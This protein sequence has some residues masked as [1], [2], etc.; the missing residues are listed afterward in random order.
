MEWGCILKSYF[1]LIS[2]KS[3]FRPIILSQISLRGPNHPHP[4][5]R[6]LI[7]CV[8]VWICLPL[9]DCGHYSR[10]PV[11]VVSLTQIKDIALLVVVSL[12]GCWSVTCW[13]VHI[14]SVPHCESIFIYALVIH[15]G[16]QCILVYI[17]HW[18]C[19]SFINQFMI[20]WSRNRNPVE[21]EQCLFLSWYE[22][23]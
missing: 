2:L 8:I 19:R 17:W 15:S 9:V 23:M 18:G 6:V 20:G 12:K 10:W 21:L 14:C 5:S 13:W 7:L 11:P 16:R 22:Y 4:P 1:A 3:S